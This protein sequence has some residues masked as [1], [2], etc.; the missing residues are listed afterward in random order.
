MDGRV[1][2]VL[3]GIIIALNLVVVR[4]DALLNN[5]VELMFVGIFLMLLTKFSGLLTFQTLEFLLM[6]NTSTI[7]AHYVY[8]I[9]YVINDYL[10]FDEVQK[11]KVNKELFSFYQFRPIIYFNR[12]A[13]IIVYFI[14][15]YMLLTFISAIQ[16][17]FIVLIYPLLLTLISFIHSTSKRYRHVTFIVLRILK[18]ILFLNFTCCYISHVCSES[19]ILALTA[20]I[21]PVLLFHWKSYKHSKKQFFFYWTD[22][23]AYLYIALMVL[24]PSMLLVIVSD[25]IAPFMM[26]SI[27]MLPFLVVRQLLRLKFGARNPNFYAHLKRLSLL[28][29]FTLIITMIYPL[30]LP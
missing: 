13:T 8:S 19:A 27:L 29:L 1:H 17:S 10:D 2:K 3:K 16:L 25:M 22:S 30:L 12:S 26:S 15:L 20:L 23:R 7:I 4:I 11:L 5:Y 24:T 9:T 14:L 18:Y 6:L 21:L 28:A